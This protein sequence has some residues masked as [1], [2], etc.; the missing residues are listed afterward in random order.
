MIVFL[1]GCCD[2]GMNDEY[3]RYKKCKEQYEIQEEKLQEF[4]D[5]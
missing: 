3:K 4:W 5:D 1:S 2:N